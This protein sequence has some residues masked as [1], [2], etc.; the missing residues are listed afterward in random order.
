MGFVP[1]V[2]YSTDLGNTCTSTCSNHY[3]PTFKLVLHKYLGLCCKIRSTHNPSQRA[4][5]WPEGRPQAP[6]LAPA[7]TLQV[8][9]QARRPREVDG[10]PRMS[11]EVYGTCLSAGHQQASAIGSPLSVLFDCPSAPM[12]KGS[13]SSRH[14]RVFNSAIG[15]SIPSPADRDESPLTRQWQEPLRKRRL[16][17]PS[18]LAFSPERPQDSAGELR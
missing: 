18:R 3:M 11:M 2:Q 10:Q 9:T 5:A 4:P 12:D 13:D 6:V 7:R 14:N 15:V 16:G 17:T 1:A 8:C